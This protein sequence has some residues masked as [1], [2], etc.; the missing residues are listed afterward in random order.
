MMENKFIFT[1][2]EN[3]A[4]ALINMGVKLIQSQNGQWLFLNEG[5]MNFAHLDKIVYTNKLFV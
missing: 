3:T 2:S 4:K 1:D 5:K